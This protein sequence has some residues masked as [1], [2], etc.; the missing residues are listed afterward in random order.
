MSFSLIPA[1]WAADRTTDK[2]VQVSGYR[3]CGYTA[4]AIAD[5]NM[6]SF[7]TLFGSAV[8]DSI[9]LVNHY[10]Q[11]V[12]KEGLAMC[13]AIVHGSNESLV[14]IL[15]TAPTAAPAVVPIITKGHKPGNEI[16]APLSVV[17]LGGL[18]TS[19][20]LNFVVVSSGYA[21]IHKISKQN[22]QRI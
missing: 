11:L 16:A 15:M 17:F 2:Q 4:I 12:E 10:R 9:L 20:F 3:V 13:D 19:A 7:I 1:Y 22:K 21:A 5:A 14:P 8:R 18:L 6:V